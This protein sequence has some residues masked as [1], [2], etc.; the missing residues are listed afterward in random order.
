MMS[1]GDEDEWENIVDAEVT[2]RMKL[3]IWTAAEN[4]EEQKLACVYAPGMWMKVEYV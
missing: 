3:V 2:D 1:S 4:K